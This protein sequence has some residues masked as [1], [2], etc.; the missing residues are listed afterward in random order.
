MGGSPRGLRQLCRGGSWSKPF[1]GSSPI[2]NIKSLARESPKNDRFGRE[3]KLAMNENAVS[4]RPRDAMSTCES[5]QRS[6][7]RK[8]KFKTM[9]KPRE[10]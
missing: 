6:C 8:E 2:L 4:A 1:R 7:K 3:S 10:T 9:Q 5:I